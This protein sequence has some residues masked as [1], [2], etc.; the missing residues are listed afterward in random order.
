MSARRRG[1]LFVY[2]DDDRQLRV[3]QPRQ[4]VAVLELREDAKAGD[5]LLLT[6][7]DLNDL[8]F[9]IGPARDMRARMAERREH[10]GA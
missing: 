9:A 7:R 8:Q 3:G 6:D 4:P 1:P 2:Y 5:Q 10:A